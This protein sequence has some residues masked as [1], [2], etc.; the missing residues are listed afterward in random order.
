[1]GT[2]TLERIAA[3]SQILNSFAKSGAMCFAATHDIELTHIL[4]KEF[5]NYHFQEQVE[6]NLVLFDYLLYRGRAV[7]RNA[8]KLLGIMGYSQDIIDRADQAANYFLEHGE[9]RSI[10]I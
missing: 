8:I 9:W 4:E 2:N 6:D 1:M 5:S 10:Q 3:S 7:S